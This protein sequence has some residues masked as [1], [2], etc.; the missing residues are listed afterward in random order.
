M[1]F[2]TIFT[3]F[4]FFIIQ[5]PAQSC[6]QDCQRTERFTGTLPTIGGYSNYNESICFEAYGYSA[7]ITTGSNWNNWVYLQ[8]LSEPGCVLNIQQSINMNV[9]KKVYMTTYDNSYINVDY[10]SMNKSDT[11]YVN[12]N[13]VVIANLIS[14]NTLDVHETINAI[15][16]DRQDGYITANGNIYHVGDTILSANGTGNKVLVSSC[17]PDD[18]MPIELISFEAYT[19]QNKCR[20][21]WISASEVNSRGYHVEHSSNYGTTWHAVGFV[22]S[23]NSISGGSHEFT[24][25][26]PVKGMNY[27]RLKMEDLD[28][29]ISYSNVRSAVI[30]SSAKYNL[31]PNPA[32]DEITV[33]GLSNGESISVYDIYGNKV[34]VGYESKIDLSDLSS[35]FYILQIKDTN[36]APKEVLKFVK[37]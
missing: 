6:Y 28:G 19:S 35:G 24:H 12:G 27:Y 33:S 17:E 20:L 23:S 2:F 22:S 29:S 34:C 36:D 31:F 11:L 37:N 16:L 30:E 10:I 21:A 14:N 8:F 4:I 1:R 3:I 25:T 26:Y 32:S 15:M 13:N 7:L 5:S 18:P 9:N